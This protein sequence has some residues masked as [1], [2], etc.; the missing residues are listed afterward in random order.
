MRLDFIACLV[1][2][3]I[4]TQSASAYVDPGLGSYVVQMAIAGVVSALYAMK[5]FWKKVVS[6]VSRILTRAKSK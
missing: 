4:V 6:L 2:F 1:L 3:L 5:L